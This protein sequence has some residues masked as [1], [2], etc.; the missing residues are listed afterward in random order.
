MSAMPANAAAAPMAASP[1]LS[2]QQTAEAVRDRMLVND[3]ATRACGMRVT[4]VGPGTATLAMTVRNDMLNGFD[5]CHGGFITLLADSAF[6]FACN[7]ANEQTVAAGLSIDFMAPAREGDELTA[8][9]AE[10]TLAGRAGFYDV[11]VRNQRGECIAVMRGRSHRFAGKPVVETT[12]L[13]AAPHG[14]TP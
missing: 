13:V 11:Q 5:T 4:A 14:G 2:A 9:A 8:V 10:V 3:R 1:A 12:P 6:A 7:S